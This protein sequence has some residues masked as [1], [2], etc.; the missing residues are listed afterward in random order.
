MK[1]TI[2]SLTAF[3]CLCPFGFADEAKPHKKR[4][5][6][7]Q[8]RVE[9]RDL[10]KDGKTVERSRADEAVIEKQAAVAIDQVKDDLQEKQK[11]MELQVEE[12]GDQVKNLERRIAELEGKRLKQIPEQSKSVPQPVPG[13]PKRYSAP[14]YYGDPQPNYGGQF[15]QIPNPE[16]LKEF[17]MPIVPEDFNGSNSV[18]NSRS[19]PEFYPR[20]NATM[21]RMEPKQEH[22]MQRTEPPKNRDGWQ[23]FQYNGADFFIVPAD[24][25]E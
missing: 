4:N 24:K 9:V 25:V 8:S 19:M 14:Q 21:P 18:P 13:P 10:E 5:K 16:D 17:R 20:P 12:L 11:A 6:Q 15:R 23:R 3:L 2:A 7:K 1:R 22:Q